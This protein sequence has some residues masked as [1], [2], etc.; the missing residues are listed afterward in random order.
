MLRKLGNHV[1]G[2]DV[3]SV[4]W[5]QVIKLADSRHCCLECTHSGATSAGA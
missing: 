1:V 3:G 5:V 4:S 2:I